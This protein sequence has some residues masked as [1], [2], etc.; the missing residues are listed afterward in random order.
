MNTETAPTRRQLMIAGAGAALTLSLPL[1]LAAASPSKIQV[2]K[3]PTCGCCKMWVEHLTASGFEVEAEDLAEL[4]AV[5]QMAGVPD[6]LLSCHTGIVEGY[7]VEGH[8]PAAAIDKLLAERPSI[9]GLAVPGMPAG[10][11]G[12]PS[13]EPERYDVIAFGDSKDRVFMNFI[14]TDPA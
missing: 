2:F 12:M 9:K 5:K 6:H 10:S 1:E 11:P 14:E 13:P 4:D 8:V 7:T 3:T